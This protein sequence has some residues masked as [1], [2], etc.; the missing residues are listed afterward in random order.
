MEFTLPPPPPFP[1]IVFRF[2]E[3]ASLDLRFTFTPMHGVGGDPVRRAFR[4]FNHRDLVPVAEQMD[5]DPEFPTVSFPNPEEGKS[6]LV[7]SSQ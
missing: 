6:A 1:P 4:A 3:N 2:S 7:S 5:P